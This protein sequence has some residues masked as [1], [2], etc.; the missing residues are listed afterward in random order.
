[1]LR[2]RIIRLLRDPR[3]VRPWL[4][5]I[6]SSF[7]QYGEDRIFNVLLHPSA[8]G[9][10]V[11]VGS[12]HPHDGSNTYGLYLRGWRG[13]TVD[14]NPAFRDDYAHWRPH[15][16]H[17]VE[18]VSETPG[19]L[20]YHEFENSLYNT[21][22]DSRAANLA[23]GGTIAIRT[24]QVATRPLRG[25]VEEH[26]GGR[27]IDLLSVDCEGL[28]LQVIRSLDLTRHRPTVVIMEDYARLTMFRTG[29]GDSELH[30]FLTAN[31]YAPFAQLAY[32]ALYVADNY[33]ELMQRSP[34]YDVDRIQGGILSS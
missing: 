34:A 4:G 7:S 25:M 11:D 1:M 8:A 32:S 21:L 33:R 23:A 5:S 30:S 10:Y 28:D 22:S 12:H 3:A 20:T 19:L 15:E 27:Q 31:G 14:A 17:L 18:G 16:P 24:S 29:R 2:E 9:T 26:L 13:L 6:N